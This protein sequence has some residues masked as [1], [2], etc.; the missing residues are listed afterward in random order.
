M[1][2]GLTRVVLNKMMLMKLEQIEPQLVILFVQYNSDLAQK[3]A[4][5]VI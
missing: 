1:F 4:L 2:Y 5:V 3:W